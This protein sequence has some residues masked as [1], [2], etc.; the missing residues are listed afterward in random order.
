MY[1]Y[2][3]AIWLGAA[4]TAT[5]AG[6]C[7]DYGICGFEADIE[8]V[9]LSQTYICSPTI[10]TSSQN[11]TNVQHL[12]ACSKMGFEENVFHSKLT[13]NNNPVADDNNQLQVNIFDSSDDYGRYAG[14]I[15]GISTNNG[16][17]DL[18]VRFGAAPTT[19]TYDCRP[20]VR[21]NEESCDMTTAQAGTY[22]L[23]VRGYNAYETS[24][25]GSYAGGN[26]VLDVCATQ[27]PI[28]DGRL[29]DGVAACLSSAETVW[30]SIGDI[31][32]HN[33]IAI[34]TGNGSGDLAIEYKNGGWPSAS[35]N[36]GSS[37]NGGNSECTYITVS[38]DY[39]NYL[40]VSGDAQGASIV[41]DFDT[42]DCR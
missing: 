5:Y 14:V 22:H 17:G 7:A 25:T 13:T 3:D 18:Y 16:D 12:A 23:M 42:T 41:I 20:Y 24:L 38:T 4:D 39:W 1:G 35:D 31:S 28:T 15:F 37:N 6:N 11:M 40:K 32:S 19:D 10:K 8:K 9:A 33:S 2:G 26:P 34:S 27:P 30:L 29:E 36:H 21:G